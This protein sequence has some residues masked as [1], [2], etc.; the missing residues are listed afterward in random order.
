MKS[1]PARAETYSAGATAKALLADA[2]IGTLGTLT[3]EGAPFASL[4]TV[5]PAEDGAPLMLLSR[6]AVH[7][8]NLA[9]DSRASLLLAEEAGPGDPLTCTR[10]TLTGEVIAL[11]KDLATKAR[12]L[13]SH[14]DA[15]GYADFAD[16]GF[17][18]FDVAGAHLVAGFGRISDLAPAEFLP[19]RVEKG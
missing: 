18:R 2:R 15:A 12:F 4:V 19:A 7:T 11:G 13:A 9:R 17:Y 5:A 6:L 16:F 1:T 8:Q 3:V 14:P 10:L